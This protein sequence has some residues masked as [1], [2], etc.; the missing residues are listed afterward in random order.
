[1]VQ[2]YEFQNFAEKCESLIF[3]FHLSTKNPFEHCFLAELVATKI[4]CLHFH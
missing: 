3:F 4:F 1:M 2:Y